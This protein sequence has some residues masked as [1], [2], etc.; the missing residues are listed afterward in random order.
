MQ[1]L[2]KGCI[3]EKINI[4]FS[5]NYTMSE[6]NYYDIF[7]TTNVFNNTCENDHICNKVKESKLNLLTTIKI[8]F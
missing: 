7:P 2:W 5:M 6:Y 3:N 8:G 1:T 4:D